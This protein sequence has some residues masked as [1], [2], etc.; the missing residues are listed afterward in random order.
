LSGAPS[1]C[2]IPAASRPTDASRSAVAQLLFEIQTIFG[3]DACG[4]ALFG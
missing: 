3:F 1:S 2:A 4:A